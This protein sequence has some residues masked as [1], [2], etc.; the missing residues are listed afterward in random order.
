MPLQ[1]IQRRRAPDI[2]ENLALMGE[3][4]LKARKDTEDRRMAR[5][6]SNIANAYKI[7]QT[8]KLNLEA[9]GVDPLDQAKIDYY[10][11]KTGMG[12][13]LT[14]GQR[15]AKDRATTD[16]FST[17]EG[18]RVKRDAL[19]KAKTSLPKVP[20]GFMGKVQLMGMRAFDPSNPVLTDWQNLKSVLTDAQL[21]NTAKT[22]GAIS[23]REMELFAKAAAN[24]DLVSISRMTPVL[25]RLGAFLNSEEAAKFG[26][27]EKNYGEDPRTWF[28]QMGIGRTEV[29]S[30]IPK[31]KSGGQIMVDAAGNRAM[32]YPDGT[33]EEL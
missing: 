13:S 29:S 16:I 6:E 24:D 3:N 26:A 17:V 30:G 20:Q 21:M 9:E 19:G 25:D 10:R 22:K 7:A 18:N 5:E 14:P 8:N 2:Y 27:Y 11:A 4:Y 33:V 31:K 1:V 12:P 28:D 32:V 23:D 15:L